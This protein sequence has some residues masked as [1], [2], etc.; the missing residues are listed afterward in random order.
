MEDFEMPIIE[1][2][3]Q[4]Q[5]VKLA[6]KLNQD[7]VIVDLL[8]FASQDYS[9]YTDFTLIEIKEKDLNNIQPFKT[10]YINGELVYSEEYSQ[11]YYD[12]QNIEQ[13]KLHTQVQIQEIEEWFNEYDLQVKQYE[14]DTRLGITG[15]YHI[16]EMTYTIAELDQEA[17]S[18]AY[19]IN[20]LRQELKNMQ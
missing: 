11:E 14:R 15:T 9:E 6:V 13:Q 7:N 17:T 3:E 18:K 4:E 10:K 19:Q 20:I 2:E 16:G 1:N 8:Y 12:F 5:M